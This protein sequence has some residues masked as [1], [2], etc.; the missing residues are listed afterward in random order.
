MWQMFK[1]SKRKE[2]H[3]VNGNHTSN[4]CFVFDLWW[5]WILL[6]QAGPL[7]AAQVPPVKRRRAFRRLLIKE[8][9]GI[10]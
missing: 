4:H 6:E 7:T 10:G 2:K 8:A 1:I 5:W 3:N 9:M